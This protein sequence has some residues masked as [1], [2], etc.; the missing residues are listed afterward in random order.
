MLAQ[1]Q[2]NANPAAIAA[3]T[4]KDQFCHYVRVKHPETEDEIG[5]PVY[6]ESDSVPVV[7][8]EI[9]KQKGERRLVGYETIDAQPA[10]PF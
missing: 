1:D 7:F 9:A 2:A 10:C 3:P 4:T 8:K 5:F 6:T